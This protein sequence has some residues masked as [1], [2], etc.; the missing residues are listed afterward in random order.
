MICRTESCVNFLRE[1]DR[2]FNPASGPASSANGTVGQDACTLCSSAMLNLVAA[3]R[4][5]WLV[6]WEL[7]GWQRA[8]LVVGLELR[9]HRWLL[10][11]HVP[12]RVLT[13]LAADPPP[14]AASA[15][16][17]ASRLPIQVL[18]NVMCCLRYV[19]EYSLEETGCIREPE[20]STTGCCRG[21]RV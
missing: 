15:A 11:S 20:L 6:A 7:V 19:H 9:H 16:P 14:I 10:G 4:M 13:M 2:S 21:R 18:P 5:R 17:T 8:G 1:C 12:H 3:E